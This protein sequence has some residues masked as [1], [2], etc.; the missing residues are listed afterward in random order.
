MS[1]EDIRPVPAAPLIE[2][3]MDKVDLLF[4]REHTIH[5]IHH[6]ITFDGHLTGFGQIAIQFQQRVQPPRLFFLILPLSLSH[7]F[8]CH[9][10]GC[11]TIASLVI[12]CMQRIVIVLFQTHH[13]Q[14]VVAEHLTVYAFY[15]EGL[16]ALV[17]H[18]RQ[19]LAE[20]RGEHWFIG[21]LPD[22]PL[23][24]SF[25]QSGII[26]PHPPEDCLIDHLQHRVLGGVAT[27]LDTF[28]S[29]TDR[30]RG[31]ALHHLTG[32]QFRFQQLTVHLLLRSLLNN[33]LENLVLRL[34][35]ILVL[36]LRSFLP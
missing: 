36:C 3:V 6:L 24:I 22:F 23:L 31:D 17:L 8:Q 25:R 10:T 28:H 12:I 7:Y 21:F 34:R 15:D 14:Q 9:Q 18:L 20:F 16:I 4:C 29:G 13:T 1:L 2:G 27:L 33:L 5:A 30:V 32:V 11:L 19:L 35:E 26:L